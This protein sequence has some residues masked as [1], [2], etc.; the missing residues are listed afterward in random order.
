MP[1]SRV[2]E[3]C[4]AI[5]WPL[6]II[7][8]VFGALLGFIFFTNITLGQRG[9]RWFRMMVNFEGKSLPKPVSRAG[10]FVCIALGFCVG[11]WPAYLMQFHANTVQRWEEDLEESLHVSRAISLGI[12]LTILALYYFLLIGVIVRSF[13][14]A[15]LNKQYGKANR[16]VK[17]SDRKEEGEKERLLAILNPVKHHKA[18]KEYEKYLKKQGKSSKND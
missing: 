9:R 5:S 13:A 14:S 2:R 12:S 17:K 10:T 6:F 11:T 1:Y 8:G 16:K 4:K 18:V 7:G 3:L 15:S